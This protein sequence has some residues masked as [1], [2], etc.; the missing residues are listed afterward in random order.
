MRLHHSHRS[1]WST[2]IRAI[3][4]ALISMSTIFGTLAFLAVPAGA[5]TVP[6]VPLNLVAVRGNSSVTVTWSAPASDGGNGVIAY[7]VASSQGNGC[8]QAYRFSCTF[9]VSNFTDV[10][11]SATAKNN[12]GW[13][14]KSPTVVLPAVTVPT[15]STPVA[16]AAPASQRAVNVSW[17][18][19]PTI[20]GV[21]PYSYTVYCST[22]SAP[23]AVCAT[24]PYGYGTSTSIQSLAIG[25]TYVFSIVAN[26]QDPYTKQFVSSPRSQGG[27]PFTY[28]GPPGTPDNLV[29]TPGV[30]SV[31]LRWTPPAFN[32][33]SPIT[34]Y[35]VTVYRG[36]GYT[37]LTT[38]TT[39]GL[40]TTISNLPE[41]TL[42]RVEVTAV[43]GAGKGVQAVE[44]STTL[45]Q[46][47]VVPS[48]P[49]N[50]VAVG[51]HDGWAK[52]TWS[53][54]ASDGNAPITSYTVTA[55]PGGQTCTS[56]NWLECDVVPLTPGSAVTFTVTATNSVGTGLASPPS[57]TVTTPA[58]PTTPEGTAPGAPQ[59]LT[60]T[61][62]A[63]N[64]L[65][66]SWLPPSDDGNFPITKYVV[67]SEEGGASCTYMVS[68]PERDT[69]R[70]DG[71]DSFT[72][73]T[74]FV[75]ASNEIGEG[76][77]T[78][79]GPTTAASRVVLNPTGGKT[80]SDGLRVTYYD[81]QLQVERNGED[82]LYGEGRLPPSRF[83]FNYFAL[84]IKQGSRSELIVPSDVVDSAR[85]NEANGII[86]VNPFTTSSVVQT[87][88]SFVATLTRTYSHN[89]AGKELKEV[90]LVITGTYH[91]PDP[92]MHLTVKVI[93]PPG[94]TDQFSLYH[95][96]DTYFSGSDE[97][98][99]YYRPATDNCSS[100]QLGVYQG[101]T[102][103]A[104]T[105]V[106][107]MQ[108][109]DGMP[110]S[111]YL[112]GSYDDVVWGGEGEYRPGQFTLQPFNNT[113]DTNPTTDN[114]FGINYQLGSAPGTYQS[115]NLLTFENGEPQCPATNRKTKPS[116]ALTPSAVAGNAQATVSWTPPATDGGSPIASYTVTATPGGK[117]CS[118]L[119]AT[120]ET[121]TCTVTGLTNGTS[122]RFAV[123]A[124]NAVGSGPGGT[125]NAVVPLGPPSIPRAPSATLATTSAT[126]SW[127][128]PAAD[129]G[130]P[131]TRY[132]VTAS[133]GGQTCTTTS[134]SCVLT[135]L[136]RTASFTA[137]IIATNAVGNSPSA[138]VGPLTTP[139]DLPGSVLNPTAVAGNAQATVS[140]SP[141]ADNGGSPVTGYTV[142]SSPGGQSCST[143]GALSCTVTSLTNGVTYT[144]KVTATTA[145]GTGPA[146]VSNAVTPSTVPSA[147]VAPLAVA[148]NGQATITWSLPTS[149]GGSPITG[150]LVTSSPGSLTCATT[151]QL[152]CTVTGLTNGT[153]VVFTVSASNVNGSGPPSLA[154]TAVTPVAPISSPSA[155]LNPT[156]VAGDGQ[157][158]ISWTPPSSNGGSPIVSYTVLATP[159]SAS[160]TYVVVNPETDTCTVAGLTNGTQYVFDVVAVNVA[161][162]G[163]AGLS[164]PVTPTA[165]PSNVLNP[166]A[167]A[168]NAQATVS[169]A[170]PASNGGS[171]I[172]SYTVVSSPGGFTC[173]YLVASPETDTCTVVGLTNGTL[174]GFSVT[175]TNA[176][177][178]GPAGLSN[179][180]VP[181]TV[182]SAPLTPIAV[183]SPSLAT[184]TWTVPSS[185]GGSPITGYKVVATP[186]AKSCSTTGALSCTISNLSNGTAY[187]FSIVASNKVGSG[188]PS[189]A[190]SPVTP[191]TTPSAV[192]TPTAVA[193]NAQATVTWAP[194][195]STGGS[196]ILRYN[197]TSVPGN[198]SCSYVV[199]VPETDTC[200][201]V[202]L[203]NGKLYSFVVTAVNALGSGP[204]GTSNHVTPSTVPDAPE[205]PS[206]VAADSQV[207]VSWAEPMFDGGS[208]VTS[209][210]VVALPGGQSCSTTDAF[211]CTIT[212]LTNGVPVTLSFTAA[213]VNGTGQ[214]VEIQ[215]SV[216][217]LAPP[218]IP[219]NPQMSVGVTTAAIT[220]DPP[221]SDGGSP[222]TS[223]S[224]TASP[225]GAEC[226]TAGT[227]GCTISG[228][229]PGIVYTVKIV[230]TNVVGD[231][232][233]AHVQSRVG[234]LACS[235][236][237]HFEIR[238]GHLDAST[239]FVTWTSVGTEDGF[240]NALGYR[241]AD[242]FLY[243]IGSEGGALHGTQ[244]H[245][246]RINGDGSIDDLGPVAGLPGARADVHFAAGSFDPTTDRLVV[247]QGRSVYAIDVDAKVATPITLPDGAAPIGWGMAISGD[248]LW[249]VTATGIQGVN[250]VTSDV[251][252]YALPPSVTSSHFG[253]VWIDG[254]GTTL[255]FESN[256]TGTIYQA[257]GLGGPSVSVAQVGSLAPAPQIDG[258]SCPGGS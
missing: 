104:S 161:G 166:T 192:L 52:V 90:S 108:H 240:V 97:G 5:A 233:S 18:A 56:W 71:L 218:S 30:G 206:A 77:P 207:T 23:D 116:V 93:I 38:A 86:H 48:A 119:V 106:E 124:I 211:S 165:P 155:V 186:G 225:G 121:D 55:S 136:P 212:G 4:A 81:G 226:S 251:T 12:Y 249:S 37:V 32:G 21:V 180:V 15:P 134:L 200:T 2:P 236:G 256:A 210:T 60:A 243:G 146:G 227:I 50:V 232:P 89:N 16:T 64:T 160:C 112:E 171:P 222:I 140:W 229:T 231:S 158:T 25:T 53:A 44:Y 13:S 191:A 74:F 99:G 114:A 46:P 110:W 169:W 148:G 3:V 235:P 209:Y 145:F 142:V 95:V 33:G 150:Y 164:N 151:S 123:V 31:N 107:A 35:L 24:V 122:Y 6:S 73:Y 130:S 69:C 162:N 54:P 41:S 242:G 250:L 252:T 14:Q 61:K 115:S 173:T 72:S 187:T 220:W 154:S 143:S 255:D 101:V 139:G 22:P 214:D 111:S 117:T 98:P 47:E 128:V 228:L 1:S 224:V 20:L 178:T 66:F 153:P 29:V 149:N 185:T 68:S 219:R 167:V 201:V 65:E 217:P 188:P 234:A 205:D 198:R 170:P 247:A 168:S 120:P 132:T 67:R 177:G 246:L 245:L 141:P 58:I 193:G 183:A 125:S 11:L 129:G 26:Y 195:V 230:A 126:I 174:Y 182:P 131:I 135:G 88:D 213:N 94:N 258:A 7:E 78:E 196:P 203:T 76:P 92:S 75:T 257:T 103:G 208:P 10:S 239:D 253:A 17:T 156:A 105:P 163:P 144:F 159:G 28:A 57:N 49:S 87:G 172:I 91:R 216:T 40:S 244:N 82:Q 254:S 84:G 181:L 152:S 133:P 175:A 179:Q 238:A 59:A 39:T 194:P 96:L 100:T 138:G 63:S 204:V 79:F 199:T 8:A 184:V 27:A 109:I 197:V 190:S 237:L 241:P 137:T 62:V 51:G 36:Y 127:T 223:Y 85:Y 45:A 19:S 202:G 42:V 176:T 70:I 157:A 113:V 215:P 189:V 147:P 80:Q 83:I 118:Y 43:S 221:A 102:L 34:S 9:S 248:W